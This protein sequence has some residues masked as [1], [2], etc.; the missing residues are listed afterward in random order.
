M[1]KAR[2]TICKSAFLSGDL[3]LEV[4]LALRQHFFEV[5]I[6]FRKPS[7][8]MQEVLQKHVVVPCAT[9]IDAISSLIHKNA[10]LQTTFKLLSSTIDIGTYYT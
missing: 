5:C 7:A 1:K 4:R 6:E 10:K 9:F 3:L 8:L 2:R